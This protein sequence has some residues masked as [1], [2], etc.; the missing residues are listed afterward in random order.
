MLPATHEK[1]DE[2]KENL[3]KLPARCYELRGALEAARADPRRA[4]RADEEPLGGDA[5]NI[6]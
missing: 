5:L 4:T 2:T 6:Y 3:H 1:R